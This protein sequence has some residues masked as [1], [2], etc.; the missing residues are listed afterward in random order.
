MQGFSAGFMLSKTSWNQYE[1]KN[2]GNTFISTQTKK[3][4]AKITGQ[5]VREPSA[6]ENY[7]SP[8]VPIKV[9]NSRRMR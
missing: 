6:E 3:G 7:I 2:E 5:D 8:P 1:L 4:I 9:T